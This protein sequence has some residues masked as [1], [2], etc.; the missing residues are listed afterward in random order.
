VRRVCALLHHT[1][2]LTSVPG[3][4]TR[5]TVALEATREQV[6]A[7]LPAPGVDAS[8]AGACVAVVEDDPE[9]REAMRAL[10]A[11]WGCRVLAGA[12]VREL[13]EQ[14]G[15]SGLAE[16]C[17]VVADFRLRNGATGVQA[18]DELAAAM[19]RGVPALIVSGDSDAG[20]VAHIQAS[21]HDWLPKPVPAA[22]L[23]SWLVQAVSRAQ[24]EVA[25]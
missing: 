11:R 3:R 24:A 2:S 8:L 5:F 16:V 6:V 19:G 21:G 9:V 23:R 14:F 7:E 20:R 22:R 15:A 1:V 4:G 13:R 18:I 12:D 10:L 17:A 25:P